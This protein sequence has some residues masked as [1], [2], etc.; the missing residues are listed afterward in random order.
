MHTDGYYSASFDDITIIY[1][2]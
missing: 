2:S 1:K